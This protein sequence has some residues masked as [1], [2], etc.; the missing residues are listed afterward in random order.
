MELFVEKEI[1]SPL[2]NKLKH[3]HSSGLDDF[4]INSVIDYVVHPI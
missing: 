3:K 4:L 1:L 2:E